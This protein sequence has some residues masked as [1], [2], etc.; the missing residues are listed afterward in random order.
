MLQSIEKPKVCILLSS[1]NGEKYIREQINSILAQQGVAIE[2]VIRDDGSTD[3]TIDIIHSF[4]ERIK[5]IRGNNIGCEQSF[6]ELLKYESNAD[7]Y[8]Y[9]D[10]DDYWLSEKVITEIEAICNINGPA[11][12]ACN[13][14]LC[15]EYLNIQG[16]VYSD[17]MI[18]NNRIRMKDDFLCNMH[19]CVLLWNRKL[20]NKLQNSIPD[21]MISH[22]GWVN[23]VAN[24][25]GTTVIINEP[26]IKYRIHGGNV[27]GHASSIIERAKKGVR[28]YLGKKHPHREVLAAQVLEHYGNEMDKSSNGYDT[29]CKIA[30]YKNGITDKIKLLNKD[31]I[32]QAPFPDKL[33]W[34]VC[35]IADTY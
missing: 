33:L 32:R 25:I 22:D 20:H 3:G 14:F 13:L 4:G 28:I 19:G 31:I 16:T 12:A 8:A 18:E 7:Y 11:L 30:N 29:L 6:A 34:L 26:L 24:A 10:Q 23:C 17:Q 5:L 21:R 15:D 1:Y 9:S 27:A 2:L 35:I